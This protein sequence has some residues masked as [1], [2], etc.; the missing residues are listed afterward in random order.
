MSSDPSPVTD[1][2]DLFII[3]GGVNGCAIA[4]DAAG[5]GFSVFLA[6][7]DDLASGTSSAST[8]LIHGGLRYLE[9][10][11]FRLVREALIERE[12]LWAMAPHIIEPLR[13]V[14]P[15]HKGLR[16]RW[17]LRLGLFLY[18]HIGGRKRLPPTAVLNLARDPLG[19]ALKSGYGTAFEYSDCRVDDARLVVLNARDAAARGAAIR[20]RT[21]VTGARREGEGWLVDIVDTRTG[22]AETI[23]ARMLIDAA[24]PWVG[25]GPLPDGHAVR[26]VKGSHIVVR[27]LYDDPRC[28]FF[29]NGDGRIFFA[30]PFEDAFTLIGT[31]DADFSGDP[32]AVKISDAEIDYLIAAANG[33]FAREIGR[34]D[35]VWTYSGVRALFNDGASKAQEATR[36]YVLKPGEDGRLL[37]VIGGKITTCRRLAEA[38]LGHVEA[39]LGRR[40]TEWTAGASL[41]GGDFAI[42]GFEAKL[43]G[44]SERYGFLAKDDL[45]ALF[46][47]YGTDVADILGAAQSASDLGRHFG[48]GLYAAE[49]DF[50]IEREWA[51]TVED[52][53]WRRTK[54]GLHGAEM[55]VEALGAY[56]ERC[57]NRSIPAG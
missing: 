47:R 13:F 39:A 31:T 46:R 30:I 15:H 2:V 56:L 10:Y 7:M 14:L 11:E 6:E 12:I 36:D 9:H 45:R 51:R 3:G 32:G 57:Q 50:L 38:A 20:T 27:R 23:A 44:L 19:K 8:K 24:G 26:L 35:I 28:F 42:D 49:V 55:D 18:D 22:A 33:Y 48:A 52:I 4:R 40:G 43:T 34:D 21:R 1:P 37:T 17:L 41:P 54:L 16:P 25:Q 53:L 29:Q 5:R